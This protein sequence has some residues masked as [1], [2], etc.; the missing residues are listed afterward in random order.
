[1]DR[2][3]NYHYRRVYSY[4]AKGDA[5]PVFS[6]FTFILVF[7]F[8]NILTLIDLIFS[9]G[10]GIKITMRTFDGFE[11]IY[12]LLI[13]G[14]M[15]GIFHYLFIV[16]KRHSII[17]ASEREESSGQLTKK[18]YLLLYVIC[19]IAFFVLELWL[20]QVTRGF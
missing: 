3:F 5:V 14:A 8:F 15:Y 13:I 9:V 16:K 20:R 11:R 18:Y 12:L 2:L 1:M 10:M 7:G 19:T 6:T 4:Y 17:L